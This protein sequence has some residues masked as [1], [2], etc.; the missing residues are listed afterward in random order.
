MRRVLNRLRLAFINTSIRNKFILVIA[1]TLALSFSFLS[2]ASYV[3]L[4]DDNTERAMHDTA[5][6]VE[7]S[8]RGLAYLI[9]YGLSVSRIIAANSRVQEFYS[10]YSPTNTLEQRALVR[11]FLDSIAPP[12]SSLK[13]IILYGLDGRNIGTS[14]ALISP[15]GYK[16]DE[17]QQYLDTMTRHWGASVFDY[18]QRG[19]EGCISLLKPV[20]CIQTGTIVAIQEITYTREA[21]LDLLLLPSASAGMAIVDGEGKALLSSGNTDMLPGPEDIALPQGAVQPLIQRYKRGSATSYAFISAL[22]DT[23]LRLVATVATSTIS[24]QAHQQ[25]TVIFAIIIISLLISIAGA[26][27][28]TGTLTRPIQSLKRC[29]EQVGEGNLRAKAPVLSRDEIGSMSEQFNAMLDRITGL[30]EQVTSER[31]EKQES[32]LLALQAQINPHFLYNTLTGISTLISLGMQQDAKWMIHALEIF[33]RT[34]LS[35]G[36]NIIPLDTELQNVTN[37]LDIVRYR[38]GNSFDYRLECPPELR[39][40]LIAKLTLQPLVENAIHHGLRRQLIHGQLELI[41]SK[42]ADELRVSVIDNG[43]GIPR[44]VAENFR[45]NRSHSYG[46]YNVDARIKLY[47]GPA[48]GLT[49]DTE[50]SEGAAVTVR[51]L[52]VKTRDELEVRRKEVSR[53]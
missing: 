28:L 39:S 37:Y 22:P 43:P 26:F 9:E 7:N 30:I 44:S 31:L 45:G 42:E 52:A 53:K 46:L 21:M 38:Y 16:S 13:S 12:R 1:G 18:T 14:G 6:T 50:R 20:I 41:V 17:F 25:I 4:Q 24:R 48:Y 34:S 40:Y 8:S 23:G 51:L 29:M 49:I 36:E 32:Q 2:V 35:G 27:I 33:Y 11:S 19:G 15:Y 5:A 47:F 10:V 3:T